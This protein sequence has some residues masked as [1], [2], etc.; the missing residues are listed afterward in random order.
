MVLSFFFVVLA[1]AFIE[2]ITRTHP[3]DHSTFFLVSLVTLLI[4]VPLAVG[5]LF[6]Y[7]AWH[8]RYPRSL[9]VARIAAL[10]MVVL[11]VVSMSGLI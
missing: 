3:R 2:W 6:G 4:S 5:G 1:F 9:R 10:V 8:D 11:G 7:L